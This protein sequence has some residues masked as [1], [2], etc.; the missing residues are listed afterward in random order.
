MNKEV[1]VAKELFWASSGWRI[2]EGKNGPRTVRTGK[3]IDRYLIEHLKGKA[4]L[5]LHPKQRNSFCLWAALDLDAH[6]VSTPVRIPEAIHLVGFL[7]READIV[8]YWEPSRGG[9]GAHVWIIFS[10]PG[11]SAGDLKPFLDD[12]AIDLRSSG[13]VD[14]FPSNSGLRKGQACFLP[15]FGGQAN[16]FDFDG[17]PVTL[18][19]IE[20]N[21]PKLIPPCPRSLERRRRWPPRYWRLGGLHNAAIG[22]R[23]RVAGHAA[24]AIFQSGGTFK[25]Y[26]AW[27]AK[28]RPPLATDEPESLRNW[29]AWAKREAGG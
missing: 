16:L 17:N 4:R 14:V 8:A 29:W 15:Y 7:K 23:N 2:Y 10:R 26:L 21:S 20:R 19:R 28:N 13:G 1:S 6:E 12:F 5:G 27:D 24:L 9:R 22:G 3:E 11:V 18:D 25:D